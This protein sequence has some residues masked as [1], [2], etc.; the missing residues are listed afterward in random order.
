MST[1]I[2]IGIDVHKD[3]YSL[4]SYNPENG[5][6]FYQTKCPSATENVERYMRKIQKEY[7]GCGVECCYEAGPTGYVLQRELARDGYKC[8]I[9]AP[10]T[11]VKPQ[12]GVKVKND[13]RDAE[14]L[15]KAL[16]FGQYKEVYVLD[17]K[18]EA[19]RNYTRMRDDRNDARKRARQQLLSFL[20]RMGKVYQGKSKWTNAH[21]K[22]LRGLRMEDEYDQLTLDECI[23]EEE[24][25]NGDVESFD[26]KIEEIAKD[27]RY[28]GRVGKLR[29]FAGIETHTALS[30]V[31]EIGDFT[32]FSR[33]DVFSSYL[34][35]TPGQDSSGLRV[36]MT[37]ITKAG[38][39]HLRR[40]LTESANALRNASY[41]NK[42]KRLRLRQVGQ[43]VDVI[44]YADKGSRRCKH[45]IRHLL[46]KGKP[47]NM[48]KTAAAR[49]LSCFIWGMMTGNILDPSIENASST[50]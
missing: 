37:G 12:G 40:L 46:G 14:S 32:R 13:Q 15:S 22:W 33:A 6:V 17:K 35:L 38:N 28:S 49:E 36:K 45:V 7:P 23:A 4:C 50:N 11:I 39:T 9:M 26:A 8:V 21:R 25:L 1:V 20:L 27:E 41:P 44:A 2:C 5:N 30:L 42:S 19:V 18:D 47:T 34:G 43:S 31:T 3:T 29:C 16:C 48:A 10:T 24:R